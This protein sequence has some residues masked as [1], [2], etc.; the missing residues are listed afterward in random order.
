MKKT[1]FT[2]SLFISMTF[3]WIGCRGNFTPE[4]SWIRINQLGYLPE[5][6]KVAVLGS[7]LNGTCESF[8]LCEAGS[9]KV[10]WSSHHPKFYGAYGP[11][12]ATWRLDFSS[13][14][15]SGTYYIRV[16]GL[17]SPHFRIADD[18]YDGTADF[19]LKYLR[20]QRC[21]F[22]PFLNDSCHTNDGYTIYGP[23]PDG[24]RIDA[25]GGWHDAADY[26]QYVTTSANAAFNLAF[27]WR[28]YP[29]SFS[30]EF[31]SNGLPGKN[32][33]PDVLDEARWGLDWLLRMH[34]RPDWMFNQIAD[35]RDHA[36]FRLPNM[37][38]VRYGEFEG[39]PVYFCTG[40]IQGLFKYKNRATGVASTAGKFASAFATGA[41]VFKNIDNPYSDLLLN[42]AHT[43]YAFGIKKP[44]ACQTAPGKAPYFYEEDNWVDDM[45]LGAAAIFNQTGEN[46]FAQQGEYY[47]EKENITPW[48]GA[49][50]ARHYQWYPFLNIGHYELS[51]KVSPQ[52]RQKLISYYRRGIDTVFVRGK[53]NA[54]MMGVP[55]IWCSNNLV[56][57]FVTQCHLYRRMSGDSTFVE[58]EAAMRDWLFGC[59]P[60]GVSMVVGLPREGNYP[61]DVHSSLASKKGYRIDGG[62]VDGPVYGSIFKKLQYLHLT[63]EDE[64]APFQSDLVVYHDD[65][66]DYST[67]EPTMDGSAILMYYLAAMQGE[68]H[69]FR[70]NFSYDRGAVIRGDRSL[71]E[72]ALVFTGGD[73]ADGGDYIRSVMQAN[74]LKA[75][76]FFTGDFYRNPQFNSI[77]SGLRDDG[78]YLGAHSDKHLL[79][80]DWTKRD[81][82][83]ITREQFKD[84]LLANYSEMEKFGLSRT[85]APYF[86]PPYEWFND[87][88]AVWTKELGLQL[89]NYSPGTRSAADYT[90]PDMDSRYVSSASIMK[91]I[92]QYERSFADGLNG[93][94][95]LIHIGSHPDRTDKF[96]LLL[97]PLLEE[98]KNKGYTFK[99]I[100]ELLK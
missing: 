38:S 48:M 6:K 9:G 43:A 19:L 54:F 72:I 11:F 85:S 78:H 66:G 18:V 7:K 91:N 1:V 17:R 20:Q 75:S 77:I 87:S 92:Q 16:D 28:E 64:Y 70:P 73:Y 15:Q 53:N 49:D 57:A 33:I 5:S 34:S 4:D 99:R 71:K 29:N 36:G 31:Q 94:I 88:I 45:E 26:L 56:S 59:N 46:S 12:A 68:G 2:L 40:E 100:D 41:G 60:W 95:L 10:V 82:L 32:S 52:L 93:F 55:F 63:Q 35:D 37:D 51:R 69:H 58:L 27:A 42:K 97:G 80:C 24:T 98:L 76:F 67:N 21:G 89:I 8:E 22:N 39:R 62:L 3:I 44:G 61:K 83:L 84:D 74:K 96:Y 30:D 23:M 86:L 13:F 65:I 14:K 81:S 90:T 79:Y 50:T 25:R 47:A